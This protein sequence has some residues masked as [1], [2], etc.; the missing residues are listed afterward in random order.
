MKVNVPAH[1]PDIDCLFRI[2]IKPLH[3]ASVREWFLTNLSDH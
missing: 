2:L 3:C 1:L